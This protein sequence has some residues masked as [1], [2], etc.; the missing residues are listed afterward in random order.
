MR[1]LRVV[2]KWLWLRFSVTWSDEEKKKQGQNTH[3]HR[4]RGRET[5]HTSYAEDVRSEVASFR[6]LRKKK[7]K[8]RGLKVS[9]ILSPFLSPMYQS[10]AQLVHLVEPVGAEQVRGQRESG[11][12]LVTQ[13]QHAPLDRPHRFFETLSRS[14]NTRAGTAADHRHDTRCLHC[15]LALRFFTRTVGALG[16]ALGYGPL[17][18][19]G[20]RLH[21]KRSRWALRLLRR[22]RTLLPA[23]PRLSRWPRLAS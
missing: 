23:L 11:E 12:V 1:R 4:R 18:G 6:S 14:S 10:A 5:R 9:C 7:E 8:R 20:K 22:R 15:A 17:G 3:T 13:I 21:R 2:L 19:K 16:G